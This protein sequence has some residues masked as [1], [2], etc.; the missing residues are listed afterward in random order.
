VTDYYIS[1]VA[2]GATRE[3]TQEEYDEMLR[4]ITAYFVDIFVAM[5]DADTEFVSI[6]SSIDLT[7]YG[8]AAGI[9]RPEFN[10]YI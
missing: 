1:F 7:L 4:R 10:I 3:P 2:P 5:N 9:P 6:D 8:A